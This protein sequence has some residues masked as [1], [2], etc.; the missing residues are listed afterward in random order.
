MLKAIDSIS[1]PTDTDS[2]IGTAAQELARWIGQSGE[3]EPSI[4]RGGDPASVTLSVDASTLKNEHF[5]VETSEDSSLRII[6]G[7]GRGVLYGVQHCIEQAR[8]GRTISSFEDGPHFPIRSVDTWESPS[9]QV[10][11]LPHRGIL[12]WEKMT[13][14]QSQ[15]AY[16]DLARRLLAMRVNSMILWATFAACGDPFEDWP[17]HA[18]S[19]ESFAQLFDRY[20]IDV[21]LAVRYV[22]EVKIGDPV[23]LCPFSDEVVG[24][25]KRFTE[26]VRTSMP[27]VRNLMVCGCGEGA[28]GPHG[29][30]SEACRDLSGRERM[31]AA[32]RM[33]SDMWRSAGGRILWL[34]VGDQASNAEDECGLLGGWSD[35]I[36]DNVTILASHRYWELRITYPRH[37]IWRSIGTNEEGRTPY[38]TFMSVVGDTS[39]MNFLPCALAPAWR[40][41]FVAAAEKRTEGFEADIT[42][43]PEYFDHPLNMS[44]WYAYGRLC[45]D[46]YDDVDRILSDWLALEFGPAAVEFLDGLKQTYDA[47]IGALWLRGGLT[48][49]HSYIPHFK[50]LDTRL[51]GPWAVWTDRVHP[52]M[53]RAGEDVLGMEM[54][55]DTYPLQE[56]DRLRRDRRYQLMFNRVKLTEAFA[57][58]LKA[59]KQEAADHMRNVLDAWQSLAGRISAERHDAVTRRLE[60]N[61]NDIAIFA[62]CFALYLDY[63]LGRLTQTE[64]DE[65]R[66]RYDGKPTGEATTGSAE[67]GWY[68]EHPG[69]QATYVELLDDLENLLHGRSLG[70]FLASGNTESQAGKRDSAP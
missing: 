52:G 5:R 38:A 32:I 3:S 22:P 61:V 43:H 66:E 47:T 9:D 26:T 62:D 16:V 17:R 69:W 31:L 25:W 8:L 51:N 56:R 48:Q 44:N 40:E 50:Y 57:D 23:E 24:R 45:W 60:E 65:I 6:G 4:V 27:S 54:P 28:S 12:D 41:D 70:D 10:W 49:C 2:R 37:P 18:A 35:E 7:D 53:D 11:C 58:E 39:G 13:S 33:V 34:A 64:I 14:A 63:K 15:P 21:G 67:D 36:P 55:L 29:A 1:V 42:V 59:E 20:G 46:P 68:W 19:I 30:D